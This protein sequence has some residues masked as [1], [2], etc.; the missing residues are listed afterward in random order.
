MIKTLPRKE[1]VMRSNTNFFAD[2]CAQIEVC[3]RRPG[4]V[5]KSGMKG[6][7]DSPDPEAIVREERSPLR[8]VGAF[9]LTYRQA[10]VFC[11]WPPVLTTVW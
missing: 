10:E 8:W 2:F 7:R 4:L 9:A 1:E 5:F 3:T 11:A 6:E